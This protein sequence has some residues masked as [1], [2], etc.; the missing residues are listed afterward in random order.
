MHIE[1]A[2]ELRELKQVRNLSPGV[3]QFE[4]P[5]GFPVLAFT[6]RARIPVSLII[7]EDRRTARG[8]D[9]L[10]HSAERH[11]QFAEAAAVDVRNIFQVEENFIVTLRNLVANGLPENAESI[12]GRNPSS[13]IHDEHR[14]R[15]SSAQ[16]EFHSYHAFRPNIL[17]L[18]GHPSDDGF[19]NGVRIDALR[20]AL[21]V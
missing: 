10:R 15:S 8:A 17:T 2:V 20:F 21:E 19:E 3:A 14:I 6:L 1:N 9:H 13:Q 5:P 7:L 18:L 12:P 16:F 4:F 11:D